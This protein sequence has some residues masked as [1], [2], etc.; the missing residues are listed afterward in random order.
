MCS[1]LYYLECGKSILKEKISKKLF[2]FGAT[3]VAL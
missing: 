2:F 1:M 3:L